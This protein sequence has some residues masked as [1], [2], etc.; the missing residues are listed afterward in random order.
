MNIS[1]KAKIYLAF[2]FLVSLLI[3]VSGTTWLTN[4]NSEHQVSELLTALH[5]KGE[6]VEMDLLTQKIRVR[7]NQ[8]LR[9]L[10]PNFAKQADGHLAEHAAL[11]TKAKSEARDER[12][13]A[14]IQRV[15]TAARAYTVSWKVVQ[16]LYAAEAQIFAEGIDAPSA[17]IRADFA[18]IRDAGASRGAGPAYHQIIEARDAFG[19]AANLA[20]RYRASLKP[21]DAAK[22]T[23]AIMRATELLKQA[24][25]VIT[26]R[27]ED[28]IAQRVAT[29]LLAWR[30][31]FDQAEQVATT[32]ASR[33]ATWTKDE[34]EVMSQGANTLRDDAERTAAAAQN[35]LLAAGALST[36]ILYTA[37]AIAVTLGAALAFLI[38]RGIVGPLTGMTD[39]MKRL[40][41]G[42]TGFPIP[43]RDNADEIGEMAKA[44]DVFRQNAIARVELEHQQVAEQSA[45]QRRADRVDQLVRGFQQTIAG[46]LEIVTSASTELDATAR[47]M[48]EIAG[49]T[50]SQAVASSAAAEETSPTCRRWQLLPKRWSPRFRR[51]NA[52]SYART[53][54]PATRL[55][56]P[57]RLTLRWYI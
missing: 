55:A 50:N 2:G 8:W 24:R 22:V 14:T 27:D 3:A 31:A 32:R 38:A 48:A 4:R 57:M 53:Q 15:E 45:R 12:E 20:L 39:A 41:Q 37:T 56:K 13:L 5:D 19:N 26:D 16:D 46:S 18:T 44:V 25:H 40:A 30:S 17:R 29:S 36:T 51:S 11:V 42:D 21:E 9:S 1:I 47:S 6:A 10:N 49:N 28:G 52:R 7:V 43:S 54:W 33:I 35:A 34:G 23:T